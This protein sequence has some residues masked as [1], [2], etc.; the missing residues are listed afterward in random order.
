MKGRIERAAG[1]PVFERYREAFF[2]ARAGASRTPTATY[3]GVAVYVGAGASHSWIWYADLLE[4]IGLFDVSFIDESA[5]GRGGLEAS[6]V[7]LIGGGDTYAMAGS[8][9]GAGALAIEGFVRRGGLYYGS[10][11]GAY[12]VLTGVDREPFSPFTLLDGSMLNVMRDPPPPRCL[13]HKYLAPYGDESVF[14]PVYG[15]VLIRPETASRGFD[16]FEGRA[17]ISA[18]LFGGPV[19]SAEKD[20]EVLASFSGLTARAAYPWP[21]ED[22]ERLVLGKAAV[23]TEAKGGGTVVASGPHLEHPLFPRANALVAEVLLRHCAKQ[24]CEG[25][26]R[27]PRGPCPGIPSKRGATGGSGERNA[28]ALLEIKRQLSNSRIV[29]FGLERIPVTWKI[30]LKVW[31]PEKIR[32]FLEVAWRRLGYLERDA[33]RA[34]SELL[35]NLAEGYA[36]VTDMVKSLRIKVESGEDSQADAFSLLNALKELTAGFLWLYFRLRLEE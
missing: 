18:P 29:G 36:G 17:A 33:D 8:L 5:I 15:E 32:M 23:V 25:V 24:G 4:R 9:G 13:E 12:L 20:T 16:C 3:P 10:C 14:H 34:P 27:A 11:A 21:R 7:L 6:D 30:G 28:R 26:S 35:D 1:D 22:A 31:E 2:A 19:L